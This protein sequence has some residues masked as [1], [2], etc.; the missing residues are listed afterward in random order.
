MNNNLKK[1]KLEY[2]RE[3]LNETKNESRKTDYSYT[4]SLIKS[5]LR[6]DL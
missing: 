6:V 4:K 5:D 1:N 2:E 3:D